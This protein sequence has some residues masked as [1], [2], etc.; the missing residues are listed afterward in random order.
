MLRTTISAIRYGYGFAPGTFAPASGPDLIRQLEESDV[1]ASEFP[2]WSWEEVNT[3]QNTVTAALYDFEK[4]N[5]AA[6]EQY[7]TLWYEHQDRMVN[8]QRQL[9]NHAIFG[10]HQFRER[11]VAFWFD[12]FT[13]SGA[14]S[15]RVR[16][17]APPFALEAI[18]PHVAGKFS[19][20]VEAAETHPAM[21]MYLDQ[22]SSVGPNSPA[23]KIVKRGL[24]ENFAR[25]L[26]EL[27]TLGVG[28]QYSQVDVRQLAELLTGFRYNGLKFSY[29]IAA[30][31]PGVKNVLGREYNTGGDRLVSV[32]KFLFDVS[33][34][35][36]TG[37]HI[38]KK[39]V[40]HFI[41]DEPNA[42]LVN[43]VAKSFSDSK[44]DLLAV[45]AAMLEHPEAWKPLGDKVKQPFDLVISGMRALGVQKKQISGLELT[46]FRN[47]VLT[48][49]IEMGQE[50]LAPQGPDGWPE[51]ASAWIT[52]ASLAARVQWSRQAAQQ[53]GQDLDPRDFVKTALQDQ[54]AQELIQAVSAA[55]S[56]SEGLALTLASPSFNR[57]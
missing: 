47:S 53:F 48:P 57:R 36:D 7:N 34:H 28:G 44:G 45:Y 30:A 10:P 46:E 5:A 43:H 37:T 16:G 13:V 39:L 56:K 18:R 14:A 9:F 3:R 22:I 25:E 52:P 33:V 32:K 29:D 2:V 54:A 11:L 12:H 35:P 51:Q 1:A 42:D 21:L 27:H 50:H 20:L 40:T 26:L 23:G 49:M 4:G 15:K 17:L 55:E 6:E 31:E 24:N 41:S 8:A 19:A 38:A